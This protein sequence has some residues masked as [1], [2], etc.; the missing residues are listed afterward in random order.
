LET[1]LYF[2]GRAFVIRPAM[3]GVAMRIFHVSEENGIRVFAPRSSRDQ[4]VPAVWG[5]SEDKLHNNLLPRD[6]P[7]VCF[8]PGPAMSESACRTLFP[9]GAF[10][11]VAIEA[12]WFERARNTR[13]YIYEFSSEIF[14]LR[15]ANAGYWI[16]RQEVRPIGME[17]VVNPLGAI[18]ERGVELRVLPHLWLLHDAVIEAGCAFSMIRMR[19]ALQRG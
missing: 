13:L 18:V 8:A 19:N 1:R 11:V 17:T 4:P 16:S 6:C 5:I 2:L 12:A 15:D 7:R 14:A 9:S 3:V 10:C